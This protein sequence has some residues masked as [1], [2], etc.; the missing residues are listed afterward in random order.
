VNDALKLLGE[1]ILRQRESKGLT[2]GQIAQTTKIS[3]R[4]LEKMEQGEFNF[5]PEV[6]VKA[7]L[8]LVSAEIGLDP[9]VMVRRLS[10]QMHPPAPVVEGGDAPSAESQAAEVEETAK[11]SAEEPQ[12]TYVRTDSAKQDEDNTQ[13]IKN[14][15]ILGI[16]L[17]AL[18]VA[19]Y[20]LFYRVPAEPPS[21]LDSGISV[22]T[23]SLESETDTTV[24]LI[25]ITAES[26]PDSIKAELLTLSLKA[27][28]TAW[29]RIVYQDSLAEEGVFSS[30]ISRT[31]MSRE[32][33]YLKIGNAGGVRLNLD[34]RDLGTP[35]DVGQVVNIL[36]NKQGITPISLAEFPPAM[37]GSRP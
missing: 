31:W 16:V 4:F 18:L 2:I 13:W 6:N 3:E 33:F 7:F 24:T 17:V 15:I 14:P 35:G 36:V 23:T 1:E 9:E 12:I 29:V 19:L 20:F 10:A 21:A 27:S 26:K 32:K 11:I 30:G 5:L 22:P 8:R 37:G 34:G 25:P 28:E